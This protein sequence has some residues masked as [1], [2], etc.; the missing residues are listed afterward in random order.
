MTLAL[1]QQRGY[2]GSANLPVEV[3]ISAKFKDNPSRGIRFT[4]GTRN[5][6]VFDL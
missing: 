6:L 2:M 5:C 1:N 3:N 4:E